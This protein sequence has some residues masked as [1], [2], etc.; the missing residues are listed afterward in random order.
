MDETLVEL[1]ETAEDGDG[2]Q[3]SGGFDAGEKSSCQPSDAS[4]V[5][6]TD[7]VDKPSGRC[8]QRQSQHLHMFRVQE[9]PGG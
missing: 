6:A 9:G 7:E 8:H 4:A 1:F 5:G 2:D 3:M